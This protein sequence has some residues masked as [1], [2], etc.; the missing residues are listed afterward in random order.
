MRLRGNERLSAYALT[1][2]CAEACYAA[3]THSF[4]SSA[5]RTNSEI[6]ANVASGASRCGE[7]RAPGNSASNL[8]HYRK[9][10][11]QRSAHPVD[12]QRAGALEV[13]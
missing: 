1:R 9:P 11:E 7:W 8:A 3:L 4:A 10:A 5:R 2:E 12:D 13:Y 6:A